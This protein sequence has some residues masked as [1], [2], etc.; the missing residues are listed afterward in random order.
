MADHKIWS[1]TRLVGT[2]AFFISYMVYNLFF[3][4]Y[5]TKLGKG[6][7]PS[8]GDDNDF[9]DVQEGFGHNSN[10]APSSLSSNASGTSKIGSSTDFNTFSTEQTTSI[11]SECSTTSSLPHSSQYVPA[12]D[13]K[14]LEIDTNNLETG[15]AD[16]K[17]L[18]GKCFSSGDL[19]DGED[20][21]VKRPDLFRFK[22]W[23]PNSEEVNGEKL[24]SG[25]DGKS[26]INR[27][28]SHDDEP[29]CKKSKERKKSLGKR[30]ISFIS[31][32]KRQKKSPEPSSKEEKSG[33]VENNFHSCLETPVVTSGT[34]M[35][36]HGEAAPRPC[37]ILSPLNVTDA[38]RL[39]L[40]DSMSSAESITSP[41]SPGYESGYMSSEGN[42]Q[43]MINLLNLF[44]IDRTFFELDT[45]VQ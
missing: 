41:I 42:V 17:E 45:A 9:S 40:T 10:T 35:S 13:S 7:R 22:S 4:E 8:E 36:C 20:S 44:L 38:R 11:T 30:F 27:S 28:I 19:D 24:E 23:S 5:E 1:V 26:V 37:E 25:K 2:D 21:A 16:Y 12:S 43:C 6:N 33:T 14:A 31:R 39:S 29:N 3:S 34:A 32:T 18:Q 15:L